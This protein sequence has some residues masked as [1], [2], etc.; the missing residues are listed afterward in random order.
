VKWWAPLFFSLHTFLSADTLRTGGVVFGGVG[1][2]VR[3]RGVP[4]QLG[5][6]GRVGITP[7]GPTRSDCCS[8]Q[9]VTII[10]IDG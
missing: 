1:L 8:N 5:G 2:V 4:T 9:A 7:S 3:D 6:G 10:L